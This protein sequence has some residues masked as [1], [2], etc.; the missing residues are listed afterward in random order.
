MDTFSKFDLNGTI[1]S[2]ISGINERIKD[3]RSH[4][5][6]KGEK[7]LDED[8]RKLTK[9]KIKKYQADLIKLEGDLTGVNSTNRIT[10]P[11]I[12]GGFL[13]A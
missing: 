9:E 2:E 4:L 8:D 11:Y 10:Q 1:Q 5:S 12:A 13:H 3:L 7:A 6:I